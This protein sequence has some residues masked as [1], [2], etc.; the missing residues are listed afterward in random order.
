[1]ARQGLLS[2]LLRGI[3]RFGNKSAKSY[4]FSGRNKRRRR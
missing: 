2:R 4:K 3:F 1:M